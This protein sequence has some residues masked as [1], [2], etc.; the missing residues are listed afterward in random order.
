MRI[1]P[2]GPFCAGPG[3]TL[4]SGI[5]LGEARLSSEHLVKAVTPEEA[6]R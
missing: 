2:A 3:L 6:P 4:V 1:G 5:E